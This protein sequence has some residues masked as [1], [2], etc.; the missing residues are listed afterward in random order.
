LLAPLKNNA[1]WKD[2]DTIEQNRLS[3]VAKKCAQLFQR[4]SSCLEGRNGYLSLRHHGL[5]HLSNRKLGALTVIHNYFIKQPNKTTA[6]ER[7]FEKKPRNLFDY[8]MKNMPPLPRPVL[9][10]ALLRRV[11]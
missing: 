3:S 9:Q 1:I 4:S 10:K 5:H 8:L 6:A 7:F 2:I 11:A